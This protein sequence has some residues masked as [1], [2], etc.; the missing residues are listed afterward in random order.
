[1]I[2]TWLVIIDFLFI[3]VLLTTI[4]WEDILLRVIS[5]RK[6]LVLAGLLAFGLL[7]QHQ[8]PNF[9]AAGAVL[10]I[11]IFLFT[12]GVIGGGDVKLLAILSLAMNSHI[13]LANF[14]IVMAFCGGFV[15]LIGFLF[16]RKSIHQ[17]GVPYAVPISLAFVL[18]HPVSF[19]FFNLPG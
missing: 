17:K 8:M 1:M 18:T 19:F 6:L 14:F 5:H 10:L 11:G 13:L 9:I 16:F 15:V 12:S 7:V 4:A 3:T 2:T